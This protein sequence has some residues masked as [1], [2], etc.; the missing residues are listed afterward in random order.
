ME[1]K[2]KIVIE[3]NAI[4]QLGK[5][6]KSQQRMIY[7]YLK[8]NLEDISDPRLFGKSL[9]G[10]LRNYWGYRVGDYRIIAEINDDEIKIIVIEVGHRKDIYKKALK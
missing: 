4:K 1:I 2:Y 10:N 8:K 5:I 6:D 9:K 3:K 7:G